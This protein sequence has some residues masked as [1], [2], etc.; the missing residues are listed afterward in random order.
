MNLKFSRKL[1]ERTAAM[2][3]SHF[4]EEQIIGIL[5][6]GEAGIRTSMPKWI[7]SC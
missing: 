6:Q 1:F 4:R 5:K 2:K 7:L 3:K